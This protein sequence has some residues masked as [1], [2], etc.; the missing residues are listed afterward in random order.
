MYVRNLVVYYSLGGNSKFMAE[1]IKSYT[2]ADI[3]ELKLKEEVKSKKI[4][5]ALN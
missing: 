5:I 1:L 4:A 2:N 3:L